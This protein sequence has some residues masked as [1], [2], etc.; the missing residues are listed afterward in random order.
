[1]TTNEIR[2]ARLNAAILAYDPSMSRAE[3]NRLCRSAGTLS[4]LSAWLGDGETRMSRL[5][6]WL[7]NVEY[8]R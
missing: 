5:L 7:F 6:W 4:P 1:M 2:D 3:L 8:V